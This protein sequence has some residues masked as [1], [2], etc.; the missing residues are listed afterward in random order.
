MCGSAAAQ[1][2][3]AVLSLIEHGFRVAEGRVNGQKGA[4]RQSLLGWQLDATLLDRQRRTTEQLCVQ[5]SD[6]FALY[7]DPELTALRRLH[8]CWCLLACLQDKRDDALVG[9]KSTALLFGDRTKQWSTGFAVTQTLGMLLAGQAAG[10]GLLYFAGVAAGAAH[11]AWQ[12]KT[13]DLQDGPDCMSKFVSNKWYGALVYAGIVADR[14]L[15][16]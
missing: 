3:G 8:P 15:A 6:L 10:C 14:L 16:A 2:A 7:G 4:G 12:I 9:V 13:V 5:F 1:Q 11:Q